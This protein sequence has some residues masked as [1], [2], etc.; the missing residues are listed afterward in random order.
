M[1]EQSSRLPSFDEMKIM[2]LEQPEALENLRQLLTAELIKNAPPCRRRRL[3]GLAFVIEAERRKARN[4]MQACIRLSR[5]ML[6]SLVE[7]KESLDMHRPCNA[8]EE[9]RTA[10]VIPFGKRQSDS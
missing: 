9:P 8:P 10:I 7:L 5:M 6:D 1:A 2:A 3:E 4:P